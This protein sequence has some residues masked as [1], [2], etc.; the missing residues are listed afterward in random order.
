[1]LLEL[2]FDS[3]QDPDLTLLADVSEVLEQIVDDTLAWAYAQ[4]SPAA[5]VLLE[6][7]GFT[8]DALMSVA[9]AMSGPTEPSVVPATSGDL[10]AEVEKATAWAARTAALSERWSGKKYTAAMEQLEDDVKQKRLQG[11]L[12]AG[13]IATS[14][15]NVRDWLAAGAGK[16]PGSDQ[17]YA[18]LIGGTLL[19]SFKGSAKD[20]A[21]RAWPSVLEELDAFVAERDAVRRE[22]A[23]LAAFARSVR[24]RVEA[25]LTRRRA[26]TFDGM[27]SR[28]ADRVTCDGGA[29][30]A[31]AMRIRERFDAAFVD[32]FQDTDDAQWR[33]IEAAL[34]GHRRLFLIGDPK[35]AIYAFRGADVNVYL[36][37]SRVVDESHR[38][39][40]TF[41]W[42][43]D[44]RAVKAL[45]VLWR[46]DS[47]AFDQ[48][49]ID[50]V[51]VSA[52]KPPGSIQSA[53]AS[54]CDGSTIAS[55]EAPRGTR[56][57]ARSTGSSRDSRLARPWPGSA[58]SAAASSRDERSSRRS[59][60]ATSS[61]WTWRSW[62][63]A[64]PRRGRCSRH[65]V[66]PACRPSP[67][68]RTR[69]ST[70]PSPA[71]SPR[72][73]RP[74]RAAGAIGRRGRPS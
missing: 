36:A 44:P 14:A 63:T 45:N 52:K 18:R 29:R 40:M 23:P 46:P 54:S 11:R 72:G 28:L 67:P 3:G 24:A 74:W 4:A 53:A 12:Q 17:S 5:V 56:S 16:W 43:S 9:R 39:T 26:L 57:R 55:G 32:E 1:M 69:S 38:R 73:S 8:R 66:E 34:H 49:R 50:Y 22:L 2:A 68:R 20:L 70:R 59:K 42:R 25:E 7:V 10:H 31:L 6:E 65:S 21:K 15:R 30:S 48:E 58:T 71:G 37:A 13:W 61:R 35:Q 27:L 41:N 33:V 51:K 19:G 47:F 64:I 60:S 62:S